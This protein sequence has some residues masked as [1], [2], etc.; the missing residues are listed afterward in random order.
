MGVGPSVGTT[1]NPGGPHQEGCCRSSS[2]DRVP[3]FVRALRTGADP[4]DG[5]AD[6]ASVTLGDPLFR[7]LPTRI[8]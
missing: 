3:A 2:D 8:R 7:S 6:G 5:L 1:T 4:L